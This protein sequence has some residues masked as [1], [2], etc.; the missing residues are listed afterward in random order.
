[1][2]LSSVV[3]LFAGCIALATTAGAGPGPVPQRLG[4]ALSFTCNSNPALNL[5]PLSY[6]F[7]IKEAPNM[8]NAGAGAGKVVYNPL[9]LQFQA[10][11]EVMDQLAR[12]GSARPLACKLTQTVPE[13][14]QGRNTRAVYTWDFTLVTLSTLTVSGSDGSN[15]TAGSANVPS[16]TAQAVFEYGGLSYML[17]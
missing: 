5:T 10:T 2:K 17:N 11:K 13:S 4:A 16:V 3:I 14:A 6:R 1:M 8:A 9:T 12:I 7:E 15:T